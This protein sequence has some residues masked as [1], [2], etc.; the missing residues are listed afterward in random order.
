LTA[1]MQLKKNKTKQ[2]T[3]VYGEICL[4]CNYPCIQWTQK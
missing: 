1:E 2:W 3:L 4:T